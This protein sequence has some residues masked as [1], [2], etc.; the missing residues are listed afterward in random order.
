MF[1]QKTRVLL[2]LPQDVLDLARVLAGK[3]TTALKLP[4]SLQIVLRALIEEGLKRDGDRNLL[5]NV[6]GQAQA[7]RRIRSLAGRGGGSEGK[8]R[9]LRAG[10][11]RR[12]SGSERQRR[13][14]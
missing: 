10:I 3:A 1:E 14:A 9:T 4:V 8:R 7:V 6:E 12:L 11:P 13:G 2:V 5:A